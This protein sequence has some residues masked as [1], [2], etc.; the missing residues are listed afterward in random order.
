MPQIST[1][2][3]HELIWLTR[4]ERELFDALSAA[5]GDWLELR[6]LTRQIYHFDSAAEAQALRQTLYRLRR[7]LVEHEAPFSIES[8]LSE[9]GRSGAI[10]MRWAQS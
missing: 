7:K 3:Q 9:G 10:R 5:D 8:S 6:R 4:R 1:A 2:L